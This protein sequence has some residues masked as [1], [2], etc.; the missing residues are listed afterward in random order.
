MT[1]KI[2]LETERLRTCTIVRPA[3][4]LGTMGF[5]PKAWQ[6][7]AIGRRETPLGAF[8]SANPNWKPTEIQ[9]IRPAR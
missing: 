6:A 1:T 3:G 7:A 4:T 8:L 2:Y 9:A 5:H